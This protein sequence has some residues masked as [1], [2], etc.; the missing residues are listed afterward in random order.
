MLTLIG[1]GGRFIVI[2]KAGQPA[3]SI[4]SMDNLNK[5]LLSSCK[6]GVKTGLEMVVL[7]ANI[8]LSQL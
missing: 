3:L 7:S 8:N 5:R 6:A 1:I 4:A 2:G